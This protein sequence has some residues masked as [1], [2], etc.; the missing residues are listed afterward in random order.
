MA[1][2]LK[3]VGERQWCCLFCCNPVS[4]SGIVLNF[5][6]CCIDYGAFTAT[7]G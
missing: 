4:I 2:P 3:D 7:L 5:T 6:G 1:S